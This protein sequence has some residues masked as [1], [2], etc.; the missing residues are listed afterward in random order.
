[1]KTYTVLYAEDVP[2]YGSHDIKAENDE[3]AIEAAV[4]F[5]QRGAVTLTEGGWDSTFS[6]R[7]VHIEDPD[8]R[9]IAEDKPLDDYFLRGG[10]DADRLLCDAAKD[11]LNALLLADN[12]HWV[13]NAAITDDIEALRKICLY[14]ADWWNDRAWPTIVRAFGGDE[15]AALNLLLSSHGRQ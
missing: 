2:R 1:M 3:A 8:G 4:A 5:Y 10:G 9:M 14:Y 15:A 7:I 13:A 6:A 11:M 12:P